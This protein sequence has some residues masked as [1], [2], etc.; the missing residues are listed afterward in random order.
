M[1]K[2]KT[3]GDRGNE[4]ELHPSVNV[5]NDKE[6]LYCYARLEEAQSC[7]KRKSSP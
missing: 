6:N 2:L 1:R 7:G 4:Q 5:T 3:T